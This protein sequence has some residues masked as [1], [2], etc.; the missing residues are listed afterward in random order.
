[1]KRAVG[2]L[3]G[4]LGDGPTGEVIRQCTIEF[5]MSGVGLNFATAF[6]TLVTVTV[7]HNEE[8]VDLICRCRR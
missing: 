6:M 7:S 1:M 8:G 3:C 5:K 2:K 4:L